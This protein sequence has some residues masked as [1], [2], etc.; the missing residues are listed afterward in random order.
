MV[1]TDLGNLGKLRGIFPGLEN[2]I[3]GQGLRKVVG[4]LQVICRK[5]V[6]KK[7]LGD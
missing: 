1:F 5:G 2:C 4:I 6:E 3:F 7:Q